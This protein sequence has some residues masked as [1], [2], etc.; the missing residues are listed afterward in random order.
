MAESN[1][2]KKTGTG[3]HGKR[4]GTTATRTHAG[5]D[6]STHTHPKTTDKDTRRKTGN[7]KEG[8]L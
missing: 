1:L 4:H 8:K 7:R 3:H 5:D 2:L 6:S